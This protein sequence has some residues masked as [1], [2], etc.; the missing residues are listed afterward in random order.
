VVESEDADLAA[1]LAASRKTAPETVR[2][3]QE[4]RD[5][6]AAS[7]ETARQEQERLREEQER[8]REEQELR[9]VI[10]ASIAETQALLSDT[11]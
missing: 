6:I 3:E 7:R 11:R 8:L 10:A 1:A 4:L 5:V 2:E 9:D